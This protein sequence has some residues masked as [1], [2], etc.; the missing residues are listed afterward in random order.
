R[1]AAPKPD[2]LCRFG[3]NF[4]HHFG[5]AVVLLRPP[6]RDSNGD[7]SAG[8]YRHVDTSHGGG[9]ASGPRPTSAGHQYGS[10]PVAPVLPI[11][12]ASSYVKSPASCSTTMVWP[13]SIC[14][15][16]S[17]CCSSSGVTSRARSTSNTKNVPLLF[18]C[19]LAETLNTLPRRA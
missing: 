7:V 9:G 11:S 4:A 13:A 16:S 19:F 14:R 2:G 17:M 18:C 3:C 5:G 10:S 1:D 15:S 6:D 8:C 12:S